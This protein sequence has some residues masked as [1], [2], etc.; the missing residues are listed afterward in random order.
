MTT[1]A[2]GVA[3][4][5]LSTG[6]TRASAL[7]EA[8][9]ADQL[10]ATA[11]VCRAH[12]IRLVH[13]AGAGHVGGPLSA[14]DILTALY[15][16]VMRVDPRQPD[17]PDRDRFILSK[18][19]SSPAL[20]A[21]LA[22]RGML[23]EAALLTFDELGSPLQA[24]P[25]MR[26]SPAIDMST[27]SLGQ[28]FSAGLGIALGARRR[29]SAAHVYVLLGDGECQEGQV[30]EAAMLAERLQ[31]ANLTA[32]IDWNGQQ[33]VGWDSSADEPGRQETMV[34]PAAK[35]RAFGWQVQTVDG[36]DMAALLTALRSCRAA[37]GPTVILARTMKGKGVSFM[38][39]DNAW[40]SRVM[41]DAECAQALAELGA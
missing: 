22:A 37:T 19:H 17:W 3:P 38:E 24:H 33:Q 23:D 29:G 11:R 25:D 28:G 8:V 21:V 34:E 5:T 36:H 6:P 31:V 13:H 26:K 40:H 4:A 7:G 16:G 35:W 18:G 1:E 32:I 41:S 14:I 12:V 2:T 9:E 20:Y 10:A 27:G 39:G 15:F 30:W